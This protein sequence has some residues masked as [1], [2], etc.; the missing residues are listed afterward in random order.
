MARKKVWVHSVNWKCMVC[1][2]NPEFEHKEM[3]EHMRMVHGID[4]KNAN[5]SRSAILCLDGSGFYSN[6]FEYTVGEM[7]FW[8]IEHG[9][10]VYPEE[11]DDGMERSKQDGG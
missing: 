2:K 9:E 8:K 1:P 10:K 5:A 4:T 7:K 11:V 3:V 6:T